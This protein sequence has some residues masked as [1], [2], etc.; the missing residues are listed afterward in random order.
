MVRV[1]QRVWP[2]PVCIV[3]ALGLATIKSIM[4]SSGALAQSA[5][6]V[7]ARVGRAF[8]LGDL[9]RWV[10]DGPMLGFG[11]LYTPD[12]TDRYGLRMDWRVN[13]FDGEEFILENGGGVLIGPM[14]VHSVSL[15]FEVSALEPGSDRSGWFASFGG[16]SG[17]T[18]LRLSGFRL[19][20]NGIEENYLSVYGSAKLGH[21]WRRWTVFASGRADW[22]LI[23]GNDFRIDE[24][25]LPALDTVVPSDLQGGLSPSW[26][27]P[28]TLGLGYTF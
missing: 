16:G 20:A 2:T 5:L 24:A 12:I 3:V 7:E 19:V 25:D 27:I 26:V 8:P 18:N 13:D 14:T 17:I 21:Q 6:T 23:D 4:V 1:A 15:G 28:V 22:T 10:D 9:D 11:L